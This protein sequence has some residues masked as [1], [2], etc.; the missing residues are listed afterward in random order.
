MISES[1]NSPAAHSF[2]LSPFA[3]SDETSG[4]LA[5]AD[6]ESRDI[7]VIPVSVMV[8][9]PWGYRG[10][11]ADTPYKDNLSGLLLD[12]RTWAREGLI[13]EAVAAG[14]YR[15]GG[16]PEKAWRWLRDEVEARVAVWLYAWITSRE[17][18][19]SDGQLAVKLGAPQILLWESDYIGLPPAHAPL[20][21]EMAKSAGHQAR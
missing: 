2:V 8:Q 17:Q 18:F 7:F 4:K 9:H 6:K 10:A 12:V 13:D 15:A 21:E 1:A 14:Y 3:L 19:V 16:T 20:V 5:P 11:P